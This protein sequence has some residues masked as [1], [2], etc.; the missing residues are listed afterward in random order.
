MIRRD[1]DS[2]LQ[3]AN[4]YQSLGSF[5][6]DLPRAGMVFSFLGAVFAN[7]LTPIDPSRR[8]SLC[9]GATAFAVFLIT[10]W[11]I[12]VLDK[13][14]SLFN[15]VNV[16]AIAPVFWLLL[17]LIQSAYPLP[18]VTQENVQRAFLCIGLF[19]GGVWLGA[20]FSAWR[21]PRT[22]ELGTQIE[23][24]S[25]HLMAMA[26]IAFTLAFIRFAIPSKFDIS[27]MIMAFDGSRWAKPWSRGH[28][29][30]W[31]AFLDHFA[32]FGY[33]LPTIGALLAR[34]CGW[35]NQRTI[36]T[37]IFTLIIT[38]LMSVGGGRRIIGVMVGSGTL[39]YFLSSKRITPSSLIGLVASVALL[40]FMLQI[41]I[42]YRNDGLKK[43]FSGDLQER[44]GSKRHFHV[45]DNFLRLSQI[46]SIIPERH[47]HTT[48]RYV[49][50]VAARPIPRVFW[51]G[52]PVDAG[53]DIA[54][55]LGRE[56]VS[57]S[58]SVIGEL[59]AAFGW[60]GCL[61]GGVLYGRLARSL[62]AMA[63]RTRTGGAL[64]TYGIGL[65]ALF[66]G[67][68]SGIDLVLMSYGVLGWL[69]VAY[70]YD[71]YYERFPR[72]CP[73]RPDSPI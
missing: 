15:A 55:Y 64:I 72:Y 57:Y 71:R 44:L 43:V 61:A 36:A 34:K 24:S 59:Y 3:S 48:W 19:S 28:L 41:L 21:F 29:G 9:L 39:V 1:Y 2:R 11:F 7:L 14:K 18:G 42:L 17:D 13:P 68:R 31:D 30:G 47:P 56:R 62:V 51:P 5:W 33:A 46:V 4:T 35:M 70:V 60:F 53:F 40:L 38:A 52:K 65:L 66:A 58:S 23:P 16:V 12:A 69:A 73:Q 54:R 50:W 26:T 27:A 37:L 45:D 20:M 32:Y 22:I 6:G 49:L 63:E 8:G 67:V 25:R 10:P